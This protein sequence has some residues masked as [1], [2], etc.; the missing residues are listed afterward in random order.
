MKANRFFIVICLIFACV[1]NANVVMAQKGN[2]SVKISETGNAYELKAKYDKAKTRQVQEYM[3]ESLKGTG[4]KF[5]NTQLDAKLTLTGGINFHIKSYDGELA[6]KFDK[7]SNTADDFAR[8]KK[9]CDGI[10]D[11]VGKD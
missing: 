5:T 10:R 7:K 11:I 2:T 9:M 8:F 3:T 6:L 4:F 1:A